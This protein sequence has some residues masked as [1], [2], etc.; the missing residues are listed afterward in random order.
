MKVLWLDLETTGTSSYKNGIV[1]ACFMVEI[2]HEIKEVR[3]FNMN[4]KKEINDE[5]LTVTGL[6][7]E[8]I[9]NY[10]P[11]EEVFPKIRE[12]LCKY[13]DKFIKSDKYIAA[14]FNIAR[15]D[16]AFLNSL[17]YSQGDKY[18][19]SLVYPTFLDVA[20]IYAM[21]LDLERVE[22][23]PSYKLGSIAMELGCWTTGAHDAE[24]DTR[25]TR[26]CYYK[27]VE[28]VTGECWRKQD[29]RK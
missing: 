20:N 2:D 16:I 5:A 6:T 13:V 17:W 8:M 7:K 15:F 14:G 29:E 11:V 4:P 1:Q 3:T 24:I 21:A 10:P 28:R 25:M 27:L 23:L 12:F 9:D 19:F 26:N 18:F 22:Q